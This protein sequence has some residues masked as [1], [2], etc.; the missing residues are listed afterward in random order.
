MRVELEHPVADDLQSDAAYLRRLGAR[1]PVVNCRQ[2]QQLSRLR[3][4]LRSSLR[5]PKRN[6]VKISA[7]SNCRR[8]REPPSVRHGESQF[9]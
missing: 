6:R 4:I 3:T 1:R 7:K 8:H 5:R 2:S 9:R